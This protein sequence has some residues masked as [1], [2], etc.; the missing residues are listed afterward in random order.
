V[1]E[2]DRETPILRRPDL[3]SP[4]NQENESE[5]AVFTVLSP[6][7][8]GDEVVR[9]R[10]KETKEVVKERVKHMYQGRKYPQ[11]S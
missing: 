4:S 9:E 3:L 7:D 11:K 6:E 10:D 8:K 1:S 2:G 5:I